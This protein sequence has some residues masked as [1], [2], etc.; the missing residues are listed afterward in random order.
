MNLEIFATAVALF[1]ANNL[2]DTRWE[3]S[4]SNL[5]NSYYADHKNNLA[6][7]Q[8]RIANVADLFAT[9]AIQEAHQN[10]LANFLQLENTTT[11]AHLEQILQTMDMH[12][13]LLMKQELL[14]IS[15]AK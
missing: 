1:N 15:N 8:Q 13:E 12:K 6:F 10:L 2:E 5:R 4:A 11:Q 14:R 3:T 9:T 7:E